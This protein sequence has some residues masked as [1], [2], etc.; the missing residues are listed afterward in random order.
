MEIVLSLLAA[1]WLVGTIV[2]T[3]AFYKEWGEVPLL[4]ILMNA[5]FAWMF[6]P[7]LFF[8]ALGEMVGRIGDI[9]LF[10]R[11]KE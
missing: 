9:V 1:Y 5:T 11:R 2:T 8:P 4:A 6:W 10:K 3:G 7:C